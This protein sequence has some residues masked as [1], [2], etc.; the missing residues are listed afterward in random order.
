MA[1]TQYSMYNSQ[2]H[3]STFIPRS[4]PKSSTKISAYAHTHSVHSSPSPPSSPPEKIYS[5]ARGEKGIQPSPKDEECDEVDLMQYIHIREHPNGGASVVHMDQKEFEHLS[6]DQIEILTDMFFKEV[7]REENECT[8]RHVLGVIHNAA[9]YI[10]ELVKHFGENHPDVPIKM[11]NLRNPEIETTSFAEFATRVKNSYSNGTFRCGPLL[12][13]TLVQ[14]VSE[15][16]G[17]YFPDFLGQTI[18]FKEFT[19]PKIQPLFYDSFLS[20]I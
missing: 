14:Q 20:Y 15:E 10:P 6:Q 12:Q 11:G 19:Y 7:F 5:S 1:M 9:R 13:V 18:T 2:H 17:R 16:A 4:F 3:N 8:A